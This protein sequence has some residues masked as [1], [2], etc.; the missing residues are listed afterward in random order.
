MTSPAASPQKPAIANS[1]ASSPARQT[2]IVQQTPERLPTAKISPPTLV[3]GKWHCALR[4][5][6]AMA[7]GSIM[8]CMRVWR[9][10]K[11]L[12]QTGC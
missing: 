10:S 5:D 3:S 12:L 7:N 11:L 6:P 4:D 1:A 2:N 8:A 9:F